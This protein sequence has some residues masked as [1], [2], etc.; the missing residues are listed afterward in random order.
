MIELIKI[1]RRLLAVLVADRV[2]KP[3]QADWIL[4]PVEETTKTESEDKK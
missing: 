2:I 4:E 1:I 3:S